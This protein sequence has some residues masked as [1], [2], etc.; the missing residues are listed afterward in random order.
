MKKN[1]DNGS[2]KLILND[3][4]IKWTMNIWGS[5]LECFNLMENIH[6]GNPVFES[7]V[8]AVA[9]WKGHETF[10]MCRFCWEKLVTGSRLFSLSSM[11][12]FSVIA[13]F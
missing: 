2:I 10:R 6:C 8:P 4:A 13:V 9:I 1:K 3:L 11:A 5:W 7:L 12:L